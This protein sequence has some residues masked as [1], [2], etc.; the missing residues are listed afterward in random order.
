LIA[1]GG[2]IGLLSIVIKV[3]E[4]AGWMKPDTS[5]LARNGSAAW[6][7]MAGWGRD[8]PATRVDVVCVCA[9]KLE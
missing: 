4:D 6:R 3:L 2:V 1:A 8:V 7:Q 9:K 5:T